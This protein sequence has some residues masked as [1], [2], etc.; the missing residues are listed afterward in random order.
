M[1]PKHCPH[2]GAS[3][4]YYGRRDLIN[5]IARVVARLES[6]SPHHWGDAF[7]LGYLDGALSTALGLCTAPGCSAT[8][9]AAKRAFFDQL[10]ADDEA[11]DARIEAYLS[12][13]KREREGE[14]PIQPSDLQAPDLARGFK[15]GADG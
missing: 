6:D 2:C 9:A 5:H 4:A 15:V 7:A 10:R 11:R 3:I 12:E 8:T 13:R 1:K 14:A